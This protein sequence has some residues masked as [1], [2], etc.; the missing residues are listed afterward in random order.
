MHI[1]RLLKDFANEVTGGHREVF[2]PC[3]CM[4]NEDGMGVCEEHLKLIKALDQ[5]KEQHDE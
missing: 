5:H 4:M 1:Q 2:W 3:G